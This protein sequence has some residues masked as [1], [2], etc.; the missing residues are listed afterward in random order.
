MA[1]RS[2]SVS[3]LLAIAF[4]EVFAEEEKQ[5]ALEYNYTIGKDDRWITSP[6]Y[7]YI[8]QYIISIL[9]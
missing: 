2:A 6:H 4:F 8:V 7:T 5:N 3:E 9:K 1:L